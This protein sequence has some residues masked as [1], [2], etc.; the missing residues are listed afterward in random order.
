MDENKKELHEVMLD[1]KP[2]GDETEVLLGELDI[3]MNVVKRQKKQ[4]I[5]V[6]NNLM[7]MID[8]IK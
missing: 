5:E 1:I 7:K 6:F 3:V 8:E 4:D 2:S